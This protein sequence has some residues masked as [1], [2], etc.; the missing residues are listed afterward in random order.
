MK[1]QDATLKESGISLEQTKAGSK[2]KSF[3][4]FALPLRKKRDRNIGRHGEAAQLSKKYKDVKVA[5]LKLQDQM[6]SKQKL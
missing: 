1:L 4:L 5:Y 3:S 6:Q 2:Q